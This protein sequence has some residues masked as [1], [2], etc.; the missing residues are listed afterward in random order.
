M[1]VWTFAIRTLRR[2]WRSGELR[3]VALALAGPGVASVKVQTRTAANVRGHARDHARSLHM[4]MQRRACGRNCTVGH[5]PGR[6][7]GI[8]RKKL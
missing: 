5:G 3:V 6:S 8:A 1:K 7:T 4:R 2:E